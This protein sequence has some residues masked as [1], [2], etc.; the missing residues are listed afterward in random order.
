MAAPRWVVYQ[1][2]ITATEAAYEAIVVTIAADGRVTVSNNAVPVASG[3]RAW[4]LYYAA[5][6][7]LTS[8]GVIRRGI[9][10]HIGALLE[11]GSDWTPLD[12]G[13]QSLVTMPKYVAPVPMYVRGVSFVIRSD[14]GNNGNKLNCRILV[15]DA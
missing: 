1:L 12:S 15:G 9:V 7:L 4:S 11:S 3:D 2:G 6:S 13:V 10:T 8:A 14:G 5:C